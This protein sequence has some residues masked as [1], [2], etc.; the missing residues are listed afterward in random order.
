MLLKD[1]VI[2]VTGAGKRMGRGIA[3]AVAE[4]GAQVVVSDLK[5]ELVQEWPN[6]SR[7]VVNVRPPLI[8]DVL[9]AQVMTGDQRNG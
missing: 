4:A 1:K 5:L 2:F 3:Q 9:D 6:W 8:A 7:P